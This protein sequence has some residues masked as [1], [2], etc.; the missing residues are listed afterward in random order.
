[1]DRE[2]ANVAIQ[3]ILMHGTDQHTWN[4]DWCRRRPM[5]ALWEDTLDRAEAALAAT[6]KACQEVEGCVQGV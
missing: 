3:A 1:M 4:G 5:P 2:T 6:R